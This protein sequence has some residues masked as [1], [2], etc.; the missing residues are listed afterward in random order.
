MD[1]VGGF[2]EV[3]AELCTALCGDEIDIMDYRF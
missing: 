3:R 2:G 1:G